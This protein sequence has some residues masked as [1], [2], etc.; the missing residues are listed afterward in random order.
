MDDQNWVRKRREWDFH[1]TSYSSRRGGLLEENKCLEEDVQGLREHVAD[2]RGYINERQRIKR[3]SDSNSIFNRTNYIYYP[4]G[5]MGTPARKTRFE[6][7]V[8]AA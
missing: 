1:R 7:L 4:P 3:R 8:D 5:L 6:G 2:L